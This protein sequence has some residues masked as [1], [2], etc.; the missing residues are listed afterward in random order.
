MAAMPTEDRFAFGENWTAFLAA[1]NEDRINQAVESLRVML[2]VASLGG[3]RFLDLGS[4]SGLF[5]L[6]AHRLGA[7]VVSVDFDPQSVACTQELRQRFG[8]E[9]QSWEVRQGSVLDAGLMESLG[10]ADVVYSWG[11]LHHT[12]QM[13]RAI[14]LAA[15]RVKPG[16]RYFIAIYNDQGGAS[17]RWLAIKK[18]YH[19]LPTQLRPLWV[20]LVAG[21]YELKFAL[22]RL[23]RLKNPLPFADWRAKQAD[24]GMSVWHDWVDWIGGL[25]FEVATPERIIVPLR[26]H[27]FTLENLKTVGKGWGCNEYVFSKSATESAS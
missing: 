8:N 14:E 23:A 13:D 24:R 5:S 3:K 27:S 17:R 26:K 22:A 15:A 21:C 9:S 16:G 4:G 18:M 25:P 6:A 12:G 19:R 1:L 7:A 2:G 10:Q 11:V 20:V